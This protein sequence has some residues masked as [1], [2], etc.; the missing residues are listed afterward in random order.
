[1][2]QRPGNGFRTA[3]IRS[4]SRPPPERRR[5]RRTAMPHART[6]FSSCPD[7]GRERAGSNSWALPAQAVAASGPSRSGASRAQAASPPRRRRCPWPPGWPPGASD[8]RGKAKPAWRD[9][10]DPASRAPPPALRRH[11]PTPS[12]WAPAK[13]SA[14]RSMA[15][16]PPQRGPRQATIQRSGWRRWDQAGQARV[17]GISHAMI[18]VIALAIVKND[19][20]SHP[21]P[22]PHL[23]EPAHTHTRPPYAHPPI[24]RTPAVRSLGGSPGKSGCRLA[25]EQ[26]CALGQ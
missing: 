21:A 26:P 6:G 4:L 19:P 7:R 23:S 2:A 17:F 10:A 18:I 11:P 5:P 1:L 22:V 12:R 13:G 25:P 14:R 15:K 16:S 9:R 24:I 20:P 3:F 8:G